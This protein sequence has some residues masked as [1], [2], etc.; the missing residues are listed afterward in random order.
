[1]VVDIPFFNLIKPVSSSHLGPLFHGQTNGTSL[2]LKPNIGQRGCD[3][4]GTGKT[5]AQP[6]IATVRRRLDLNLAAFVIDGQTFPCPGAV[7]VFVEDTVGVTVPRIV[8]ECATALVDRFTCWRVH[9]CIQE[10]RDLIAVQVVG[11]G[12]GDVH[13]EEVA[14]VFGSGFS[15]NVA[16]R[17][18]ALVVGEQRGVKMPFTAGVQALIRGDRKQRMGIAGIVERCQVEADRPGN[19]RVPVIGSVQSIP[20]LILDVQQRTNH[21]NGTVEGVPCFVHPLVENLVGIGEVWF[22]ATTGCLEVLRQ[23]LR[24]RHLNEG[25]EPLTGDV[26][27]L[28]VG[29]FC[30]GG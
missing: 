3:G 25:R 29:P 26:G 14:N 15:Y 13:D 1:L 17:T 27:F 19:G 11:E 8:V 28:N 10:K 20:H 30:D 6:L 12:G 16:E 9:A 22:N 24:M 2:P 5:D 4:E 18:G 21:L 7:I 23:Y